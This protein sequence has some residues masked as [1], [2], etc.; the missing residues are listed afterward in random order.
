MNYV[1]INLISGG[2]SM[3]CQRCGFE[4]EA[5]QT[6]CS[7]CGTEQSRAERKKKWKRKRENEMIREKIEFISK[8]LFRQGISAVLKVM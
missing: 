1:I 7:M 4:L 8:Y 2:C 3:R 5:G 6:F